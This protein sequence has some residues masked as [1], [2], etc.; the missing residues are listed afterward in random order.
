[1]AASAKKYRDIG[2]E[3]HFSKSYSKVP[4]IGLSTGTWKAWVT[5]RNDACLYITY[6][7]NGIYRQ[8]SFLVATQAY[9]MPEAYPSVIGRLVR[10]I[11]V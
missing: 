1:M 8:V 3:H 2:F 7:F 11:L 6:I 5:T 4:G 9:Q 10:I